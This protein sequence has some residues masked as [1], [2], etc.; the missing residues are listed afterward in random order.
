MKKLIGILLLIMSSLAL[1]EDFGWETG[2][3]TGWTVGGGSSNAVKSTGWSSNGIGVAVS[4]GL[5]NYSPG[6]GKT[7]NINPYGTY[8]GNIQPGTGSVSF[9]S[10]AGSLGLGSTDITAIKNYLIYQSQNGGGGSPTPTNASWIKQTVTLQAGTTYTIAWN[11]LSTDYTPWNDGSMMTLVHSSDS[12]I[13]PTLNNSAKK[14]ALLG[15]TNPGTGE[16]ATG[17]YGS[18]GWQVATITVPVNGTY[19]LGFA[20]FNLGD[21]S[22]SPILFVD[23]VQG[24]TTLNGQTFGPVA[25]NAGSTAPVAPSGGSTLCCGGSAASFSADPTKVNSV[26]AFINRIT[27]DSK[28]FV[29][30]IGNSN[31]TTINQTGTRNNYVDYFVN[32]SF[33]NVSVVQSGSAT[34]QVNYIDLS[35]GTAGVSSNSNTVNLTQQST[36]GG[37]AIFATVSGSNNSLTVLQKDGGSHW[38]DITLTGGNKTVDVTQQGSASHMTKIELTG[39]PTSLNLTQSGSTQQFYSIQHNCATAGGCAAI[40]VTQGN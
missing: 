40:T 11:Y 26:N 14:Y 6:G 33:N 7:W 25:P 8:M 34:T 28:V 5:T 15:F 39:Q 31:T 30:Q 27:A 38:A 29:E 37:K 18:T 10:A 23:Q 1:A 24:S 32:G 9:D 35:I 13:T 2:T 16:Y 20:S 21:Q 12:S 19:T 4:G 17:S 22:L 36:G 3:L